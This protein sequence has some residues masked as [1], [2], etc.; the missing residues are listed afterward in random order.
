MQQLQEADVDRRHHVAVEV[1][2]EPIDVL[3]RGGDVAAVA[4]EDVVEA[5]VS[6][7]VVEQQTALTARQRECGAVESCEK[8]QA[9]RGAKNG[10]PAEGTFAGASVLRLHGGPVDRHGCVPCELSLVSGTAA[11]SYAFRSSALRAYLSH[12]MCLS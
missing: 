11:I 12:P 10:A 7:R 1:A 9:C 3:E 5:L 4:P 8:N 2:H 6:M